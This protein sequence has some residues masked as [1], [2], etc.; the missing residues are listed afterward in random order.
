MGL[1]PGAPAPIRGPPG[2]PAPGRCA[3]F[4]SGFARLLGLAFVPRPGFAAALA[5]CALRVLPRRFA[6]LVRFGAP[7]PLARVPALCP[8]SPARPRARCRAP[9]ALA[10][11]VCLRPRPRCAAG[12]LFARPCCAWPW[13]LCSAS[14]RGG[15]AWAPPGFARARSAPAPGAALRAAFPPS[16]AG[17][18]LAARGRLRPLA[19]LLRGCFLR[20]LGLRALWLGFA[21]AGAHRCCAQARF[22]G[23][24]PAPPRP[25]A[26]AGGSGERQ[27]CSRWPAGPRRGCRFSRPSPAAPPG[28]SRPPVRRFWRG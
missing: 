12:S 2:P 25:A 4:A 18:W 26:P 20:C 13:A 24:S 10:A 23:F 8:R 11:A 1:R 7:R 22:V 19:A 27:A 9:S 16:G 17:A 3:P 5:F 15:S 14:A 6:A 21:P 28:C